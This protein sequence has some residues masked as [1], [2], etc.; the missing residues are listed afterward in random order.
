MKNKNNQELI[1]KKIA[2]KDKAKEEYDKKIGDIK[3]R[4]GVNFSVDYLK[5]DNINS[6][7]FSNLTYKNK[8]R[9]IMLY[10]SGEYQ[11]FNAIT[12]ELNQNA[13]SKD[14]ND[15]TFIEKIE[16]EYKLNLVV[17]EIED[18]N[19]SYR[20]KLLEIDKKYSEKEKEQLL[21]DQDIELK[22]GLKNS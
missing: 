3:T 17:E 16:E 13:T 19:N 1:Q 21:S 15:R 2:E 4:R 6:I 11:T 5:N 12:Y 7:M 18:A 14:L 20:N 10:Y 22:K 9:N 8:A